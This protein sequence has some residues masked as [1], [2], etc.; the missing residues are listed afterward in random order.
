MALPLLV[1]VAVIAGPM[2]VVAYNYFSDS[3]KLAIIGLE[4]S[5]VTTLTNLFKNAPKPSEEG[6][7]NS[8]Q[9][10]FSKKEENEHKVDEEEKI[11]KSDFLLYLFDLNKYV[12]EEKYA[13]LARQ[14]IDFFSDWIDDKSKL[15]KMIAVGTHSDL[16][17]KQS[18]I[19]IID[20]LS[21]IFKQRNKA[22]L[23]FL[24][25]N[26]S[27]NESSERLLTSIKKAIDA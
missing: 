2:G 8:I 11:K 20:E 14:Q 17:K 4:S 5:G 10:Y 13:K 24:S 23:S 16:L 18:D 25:G 15:K 21:K 9:N 12:S 6:I 22:K 3:T 19:N 26:L 1:P 7:L 27:S